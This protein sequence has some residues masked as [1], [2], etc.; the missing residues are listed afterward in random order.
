MQIEYLV[1]NTT[2][3]LPLGLTALQ[4]MHLF[5]FLVATYLILQG[6]QSLSISKF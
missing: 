5:F 6:A 2:E 4:N 1:L 3:S